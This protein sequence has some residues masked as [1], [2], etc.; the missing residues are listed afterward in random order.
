MQPIRQPSFSRSRALQLSA[1]TE[2]A[3]SCL[4]PT[5]CLLVLSPL[6]IVPSSSISLNMSDT[7]EVVVIDDYGDEHVSSARNISQ[8]PFLQSTDIEKASPFP[9]LSAYTQ[10]EEPALN[11]LCRLLVTGIHPFATEE[12]LSC[13]FGGYGSVSS[14]QIMRDPYTGRSRGVGFITMG[15]PE[16][17][18]TATKYLHRDVS[19]GNSLCVERCHGA[20][21]SAARYCPR[22]SSRSPSPIVDLTLDGRIG[23][24]ASARHSSTRKASK[25]AETLR[26]SPPYTIVDVENNDDATPEAQRPG[27]HD[28]RRCPIPEG[29]GRALPC[30]GSSTYECSAVHMGQRPWRIP[31]PPPPPAPVQYLPY[32]KV[33]ELQRTVVGSEVPEA[34][35]NLKDCVGRKFAFPWEKCKSWDVSRLA[36]RPLAPSVLQHGT[37]D[38]QTLCR[39]TSR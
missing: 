34:P 1:R 10:T 19:K 20:P 23:K 4:Y 22:S 36:P 39:Q 6:Q 7:D 16:Q 14:C 21:S 17:A 13:I 24:D 32:V 27:T 2:A 11:P 28:P 25:K 33:E 5:L 31:P 29:V 18:D 9:P 12:E 26:P 38:V 8:P 30:N 3:R 35:I 15:T 37:G